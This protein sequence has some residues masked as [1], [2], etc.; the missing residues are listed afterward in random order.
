MKRKNGF[1]LQKIHGD[2]YA[3]AVTKESAEVG[4]MVRLNPTA[5]FLFE[6]LGEERSYEDCLGALLA[7]YEVDEETARRDLDRFLDGLKGAGLLA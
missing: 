6:L 2:T 3:I 4:S 1:V 7:Q 5:A